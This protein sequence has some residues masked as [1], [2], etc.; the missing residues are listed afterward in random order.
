MRF[1]N[2][3]HVMQIVNGQTPALLENEIERLRYEH[4]INKILNLVYG[5]MKEISHKYELD[6]I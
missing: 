1:F 5:L 6:A 2:I 4:T 3:W